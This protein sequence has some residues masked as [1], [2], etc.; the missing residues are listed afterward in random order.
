M[1]LKFQI[2]LNENFLLFFFSSKFTADLKTREKNF[3]KKFY[4]F[5]FYFNFCF[6]FILFFFE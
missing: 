1:K 4:F 5:Q 3:I 2:K 6:N